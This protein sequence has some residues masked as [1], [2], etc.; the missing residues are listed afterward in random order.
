MLR[1][2]PLL[3]LTIAVVGIVLSVTAFVISI[4]SPPV[5][6]QLVRWTEKLVIPVHL[7]LAYTLLNAILKT[8]I[9]RSFVRLVIGFSPHCF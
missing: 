5:S 4:F 7:L 3:L 2:I 8:D 1:C 6:A 9:V